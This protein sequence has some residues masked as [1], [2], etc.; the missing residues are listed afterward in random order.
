MTIKVIGQNI[1][2]HSHFHFGAYRY[3]VE[4]TDES[5]TVYKF[6]DYWTQ[7]WIGEVKQVITDECVR[8]MILECTIP[9]Q[10]ADSEKYFEHFL[11]QNEAKCYNLLDRVSRKRVEHG[12]KECKFP[13]DKCPHCGGE[14][15]SFVEEPE[16]AV[17]CFN[18]QEGFNGW[19]TWHSWEEIFECPH[20]GKRFFIEESN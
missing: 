3:V 18:S 14:I 19:E 2:D 15:T 20:C 16:N 8:E 5:T 6:Q 1:T 12:Y 11:S 9:F 17:D 4:R 10:K 7:I 13:Y